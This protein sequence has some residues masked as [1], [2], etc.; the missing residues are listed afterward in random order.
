VTDVTPAALP[1]PAPAAVRPS[2]LL[3]GLL[4]LPGVVTGFMLVFLTRKHI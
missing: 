3:T 4:I 1:R 2:R